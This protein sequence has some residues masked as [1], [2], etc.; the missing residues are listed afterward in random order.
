MRRLPLALLASLAA[1]VPSPRPSAAADD[2]PKIRALTPAFATRGQTIDVAMEGSNLAPFDEIKCGRPEISMTA[3]KSVDPH[4]VMLRFVIP[5]TAAAGPVPITLK[6]KTGVATT[7]RFQVRLRSPVVSKVKPDTVPRGGEVDVA[8]TGLNLSFLGQETQV[9]VEAPMTATVT[10]KPTDKALT[11]HLVVPAGVAPGAKSLQLTTTDGKVTAPF[12]VALAP[13][14]FTSVT[15]ATV[16]RG[17]SVEVKLV[18]KNLGGVGLPVQALP[19]PAFTFAAV[20]TASPTGFSL[21]VTAAQDA[22]PGPRLLVFA[23]SDGLAVAKIEVTTP[24][25]AIRSVLPAGA[26][27]GSSV[28]LDVVLEN[29]PGAH[30]L[31]VLPAGS[32][33]T[34]ET[35][36]GGKPRLTVAADALPGPR[37]LLLEH[38]FG[39]HAVPF[40]VNLKG[41]GVTAVVPAEVAPGAVAE[42]TIEGERLEG[43]QITLAVPDPALTLTPGKEAGD[44]ARRRGRGREARS[45][46]APRPDRRRRRDRR[47]HGR[48]RRLGGADHRLP[49]PAAR[50][51]RRHD[52]DHRQGDGAARRRRQGPRGLVERRRGR[53]AREDRRVDDVLP[54]RRG[55]AAGA[56]AARRVGARRRHAGGRRRGRARRDA[57]DA[58]ARPGRAGAVDAPR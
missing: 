24:A 32:G 8:V 20:G 34:I 45:A 56:D 37:T 30:V 42:L 25:P 17:G 57:G 49:G 54:D 27:R 40:V 52:L 55:L 12:V 6:T 18:G 36:K 7:D 44:R 5:D 2:V 48:R 39:L 14:E 23:T 31:R 38:P 9:V 41:P 10:G 53:G 51:A 50:A 29:A 15:P 3:E 26:A 4:K 58:V 43:A 1:L 35:P 16:V 19:D 33:V 22:V 13:P 11:V 28:D 46:H 47:R 21:K